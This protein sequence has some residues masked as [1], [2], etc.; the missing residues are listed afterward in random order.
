MCAEVI[1]GMCVLVSPTYGVFALLGVNSE[2]QSFASPGC[3]LL[4]PVLYI[5]VSFMPHEDECY[6]YLQEWAGAV[7]I[8]YMCVHVPVCVCCIPWLVI[9]ARWS[10]LYNKIK[11]ESAKHTSG[12]RREE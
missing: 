5:P 7:G 1:V 4:I 9:I 3:Q 12:E 8:V 2:S 10:C 6:M 11:R